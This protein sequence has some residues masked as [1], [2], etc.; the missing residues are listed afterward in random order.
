MKT[1]PDRSNGLIVDDA[2]RSRRIYDTESFG[3]FTSLLTRFPSKYCAQLARTPS[4]RD[5][6]SI[7]V[8]KY[9]YIL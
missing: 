5:V 7:V 4:V 9:M 2:Y 6:R 3:P 8:T 1:R